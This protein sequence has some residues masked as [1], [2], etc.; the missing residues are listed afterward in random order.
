MVILGFGARG[1]H[2]NSRPVIFYGIFP[3]RSFSAEMC[4]LTAVRR[5]LNFPAE[6]VMILGVWAIG[7]NLIQ[8]I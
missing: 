3:F 6:E 4:D 2:V 8:N 1:I 7:T 5:A